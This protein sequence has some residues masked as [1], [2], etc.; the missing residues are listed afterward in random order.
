MFS[1]LYFNYIPDN[2]I[3]ESSSLYGYLSISMICADQKDEWNDEEE[4]I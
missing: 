2:S 3:S 1:I 4:F